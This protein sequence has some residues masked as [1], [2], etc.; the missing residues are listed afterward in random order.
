M[1][2][3]ITN[4]ATKEFL[5]AVPNINDIQNLVFFYITKVFSA[6]CYFA[7]IPNLIWDGIKMRS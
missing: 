3:S 6:I 5:S 2:L 1:Y 4:Q 7:R